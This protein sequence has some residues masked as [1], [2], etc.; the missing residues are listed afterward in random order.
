MQK[1]WSAVDRGAER[2]ADRLVAQADPSSGVR[3]A[4]HARTRPI[5]APARSGSAGAGAEQN[6]VEVPGGRVDPVVTGQPP[7]VVAPDFRVDT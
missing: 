2:D 6:P 3:A 7:V 1:L 4:A 5:D